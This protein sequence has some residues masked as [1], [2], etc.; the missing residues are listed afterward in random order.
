MC[1]AI[2]YTMLA[3]LVTLFYLIT[4]NYDLTCLL[5]FF[6][7]C[8]K[9]QQKAKAKMTISAKEK[10]KASKYFNMF[11]DNAASENEKNKAKEMLVKLLQKHKASIN[12]FVENVDAE[13]AK[14]FDFSEK[15]KVEIERNYK[16]SDNSLKKSNNKKSRR[17][18]TITTYGIISSHSNTCYESTS[19]FCNN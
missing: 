17:A 14:L 19:E 16:L 11:V 3:Y 13:T 9:L 7:N 12:D 10:S 2:V 8:I 1:K 15:Q 18:I 6:N 5:N 4:S